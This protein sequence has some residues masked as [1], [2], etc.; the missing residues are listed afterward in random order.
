MR[1]R[2][3][4]T[5]FGPEGGGLGHSA[6]ERP[7]VFAM[8]DAFMLIVN[9]LVV[10]FKFKAEEPILA[11]R[12]P[13]GMVRFGPVVAQ[14]NKEPL[15]IKVTRGPT[16]PVYEYLTRQVSLQELSSVL[17]GTKASGREI[18]VRVQYDR[19]VPWQDIMSVFNECQKY[20]IIDCGLVPLRG[21]AP[22][23]T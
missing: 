2:R 16:G 9:F 23:K 18:Q 15:Y 14:I 1:Y 8:I 21:L 13:P 11:Q 20:Q 3:I 22:T 17:A 10:T 12:M 4:K 5:T 19:D 7:W 6:E